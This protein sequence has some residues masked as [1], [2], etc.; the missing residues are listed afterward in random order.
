M[1][2]FWD[3]PRKDAGLDLEQCGQEEENRRS[4]SR[5]ATSLSRSLELGMKVFRG[6]WE[7]PW[8]L[9]RFHLGEVGLDGTRERSLD[10]TLKTMGK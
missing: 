1:C 2:L 10:L 8:R 9:R 3:S 5:W 4:H 7:Q 6:W